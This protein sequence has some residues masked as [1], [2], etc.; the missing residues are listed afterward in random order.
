[1]VQIKICFEGFKLQQQD[2]KFKRSAYCI[3]EVIWLHW[4]Q[5]FMCKIDKW[6][7][8]VKKNCMETQSYSCAQ[9]NK[10]RPVSIIMMYPRYAFG[11]NVL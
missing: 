1:M 7:G 11:K 6:I 10:T 8:K 3:L 9:D 5:L 2:L 4:N